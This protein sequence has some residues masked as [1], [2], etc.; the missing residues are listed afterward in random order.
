MDAKDWITAILPMIGVLLGAIVQY[1]ISKSTEDYKQQQ[2]LRTQA[3]ADFLRGTAGVG[4]A[5]RAANKN[6]EL[7]NLMLMM[8]A[9]ARICVY[10]SKPVVDKL[11]DFWR[12]GATLDTPDHM[13]DFVRVC[14]AMRRESL[15][16]DQ[17][18][19]NREI[20]QLLVGQD[21]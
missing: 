3:Y 4:I 7:E 5:Q 14:Q 17:E 19:L 10:G 9:K 6:K 20:S 15:P 16:R 12:N 1:R 21:L 8:D 2:S 18:V 11:A 13:L